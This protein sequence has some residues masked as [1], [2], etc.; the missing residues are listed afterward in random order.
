MLAR[1]RSHLSYANVGVTAAVV[2]AASGFAVA[3]IPDSNGVIHGCYKR[4][5]GRLRVVNARRDCGD[6]EKPISFNKRGPVGPR[7][8]RGIQGLQG[9]QGEPGPGKI[10]DRARLSASQATTTS[11]STLVT[12]P[13]TDATW[14]QQPNEL[15]EVFG[16]L[17]YT[18]PASCVRQ[19][20]GPP[21]GDL[22]G[23]IKAEL[24][25]DGT[26]VAAA[27]GG[28]SDSSQS[29]EFAPRKVLFEPGAES[30]H[31]VSVRVADT[32]VQSGTHYTVTGVDID[33]VGNS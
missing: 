31:T 22:P 25:V 3:A 13:L 14:A 1:I 17:T 12:V 9:E 30:P 28:R 6:T 5:G 33:T 18:S 24:L 26:V 11:E 23:E 15:D 32:C 4:D 21:L 20:A 16:R 10:V 19:S 7:G 27:A 29:I 2:L 8:P